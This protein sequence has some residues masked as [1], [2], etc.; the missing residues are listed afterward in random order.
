MDG[1]NLERLR[2]AFVVYGAMNR[3][4]WRTVSFGD[5]DFDAVELASQLIPTLRL[6]TIQ[7]TR[8]A[9]VLWRDARGRMPAGVVCSVA[10]Q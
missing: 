6:G 3:K 2:I 10:F 8:G 7:G 4:D 9:G 5:V 1:L